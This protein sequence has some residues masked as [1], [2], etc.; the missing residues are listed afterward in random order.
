MGAKDE[1][2][3]LHER[4]FNCAQSVLCALGKYTGLDE[5]TAFAVA[6][7]FGGGVSCGEICGTAA[8][9]VMAFGLVFSGEPGDPAARAKVRRLSSAFN[10]EFSETFGCIRCRELKQSGHPCAELIEYAAELAEKTILENQESE[11]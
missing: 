7:G 5:K 2:T 10:R 6:G 11:K 8:G 4:G 1:A 3:A 9:A